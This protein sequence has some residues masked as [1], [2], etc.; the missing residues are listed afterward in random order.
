MNLRRGFYRLWICAAAVWLAAF[1]WYLRSKC[2]HLA[3]GTLMCWI[4]ES[5]WTKPIVEFSPRDYLCLSTI[6]LSFPIATLAGG[7][8]L[9]WIARGFRPPQSK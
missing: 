2:F 8:V 5:D 3:D 4:G 1:V 6:A 7:H 9:A